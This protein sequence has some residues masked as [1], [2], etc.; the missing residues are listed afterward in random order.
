MQCTAIK[1]VHSGMAS[2][3]SEVLVFLAIEN[4][5]GM[6]STTPTSTKRVIPQ[7][8][9]TMTMMTSGFKKRLRNRVIPIFSAAPETSSILPKI[10]PRPMMAAKKPKVPPIPFSIAPSKSLGFICINRPT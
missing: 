7:I 8:K 10:V 3:N 9:P 1:A 5:S 4:A 6:S 2:F